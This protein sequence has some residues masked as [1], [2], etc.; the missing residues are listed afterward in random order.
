MFSEPYPDLEINMLEECL[1][2]S[3]IPK[4]WFIKNKNS[5]KEEYLILLISKNEELICKNYER[6]DI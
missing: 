6:D 2:N 1:K 4:D 3:N 5:S